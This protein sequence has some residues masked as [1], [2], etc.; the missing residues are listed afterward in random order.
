VTLLKQSFIELEAQRK[1]TNVLFPMSPDI[2]RIMTFNINS[3]KNA[4][5]VHNGP[6]GVINVIKNI[7]PTIAVLQE[8][9]RNFLEV[10]QFGMFKSEAQVMK[11]EMSKLG[12]I[13]VVNGTQGLDSVIYSKI[14]FEKTQV[15]S[16]NCGRGLIDVH[17]EWTNETG[18]TKTLSVIGIHLD[19]AMDDLRISQSKS[20][21]EHLERSQNDSID[22]HVITGDFNS[23]LEWDDHV[24][25]AGIFANCKKTFVDSFCAIGWSQPYYTHWGTQKIDHVLVS[26]SLKDKV[27]GSYV[28]HTDVSDHIPVFVDLKL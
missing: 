27:V 6:M 24:T 23:Y 7:D 18:S 19:H 26:G 3:F 10:F 9:P 15:N 13:H 8:L 28:Y 12:Y 20:I 14:K 1:N 2:I 25:P 4:L 17:L 22:Y 11:E 5:D 21:L 16:L